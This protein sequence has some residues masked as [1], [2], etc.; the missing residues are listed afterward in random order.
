MLCHACLAMPY[1]VVLCHAMQSHAVPCHAVPCHAMPCR[2]P[3]CHAM[4]CRAAL[5]SMPW[6][7]SHGHAMLFILC[8]AMPCR[9]MTAWQLQ[10]LGMACSHPRAAHSTPA[11]RII[12]SS[13]QR[14]S[15]PGEN[16]E[17]FAASECAARC[18]PLPGA[19]DAAARAWQRVLHAEQPRTSFCR[20]GDRTPLLLISDSSISTH[21]HRANRPIEGSGRG[22]VPVRRSDAAKKVA[23][24]L[25]LASTV[26]DNDECM[27]F[28]VEMPA[29]R[30][31]A[32]VR[33]GA[34]NLLQL[35]QSSLMCLHNSNYLGCR[36]ACCTTTS[37]AGWRS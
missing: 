25:K 12:C 3:P 9:I 24:G 8:H 22:G 27:W 36:R 28:V 18:M 35:W 4:P 10:C 13:T 2:A 26:A 33:V 17:V 6:H 34:M 14:W 20:L 15:T 30:G 37:R 32:A 7:P 23:G 16:L 29:V 5:L 1:G 11:G 21:L 31:A 19:P